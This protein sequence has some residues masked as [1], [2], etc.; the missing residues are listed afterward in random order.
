VRGL[1]LGPEPDQDGIDDIGDKCC[2]V[3]E[4]KDGAEDL[5]GCGE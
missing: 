2:Y 4:D 3:A 1:A 5:D